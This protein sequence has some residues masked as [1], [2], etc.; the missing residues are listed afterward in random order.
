[1]HS[2]SPAVTERAYSEAWPHVT[3]SPEIIN[4]ESIM[5]PASQMVHC[6]EVE[7]GDSDVTIGVSMIVGNGAAVDGANVVDGAFVSSPFA[8]E[9]MMVGAADGAIDVVGVSL[10]GAPLDGAP[11]AGAVV[12]VVAASLERD[13]LRLSETSISKNFKART[14]LKDCPSRAAGPFFSLLYTLT[15]RRRF[16]SEMAADDDEAAWLVARVEKA[17]AALISFIVRLSKIIDK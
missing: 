14:S 7:M 2:A 1:M 4:S 8:V 6:V 11:V 12:G 10:V 16:V 9:L 13:A 3:S 15:L 5:S 17:M